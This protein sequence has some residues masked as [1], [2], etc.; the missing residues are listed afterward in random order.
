MFREITRNYPVTAAQYSKNQKGSFVPTTFRELYE[1][2]SN[3]AAGLHQLG[4]AR[5]DRLGLIADNRKEWLIADLATI[6]LGAMDVPRGRDAT[7]QE[8]IYILSFSECETIFAENLEMTLKVL[9]LKDEISSMKRIIVLDRSFSTDQLDHVPKKVEVITFDAVMELGKKKIEKRP[10][11][12]EE[13]VDK[14][15]IDDVVTIIFTSGTTG[16]PKGV[17]LTN[18]AY[19]HQ[20]SG[21]SKIVDIKPGDIWLSVLPVW[22]SFERV[23]Q[24][25]ALGTASALAYSKPIGKIMLQDFQA[26]KPQWMGSVP[27]IW[28]SIKEGIYRNVSTKSPVSRA[29]FHFFVLTGG[30]SAKMK[31][32][33]LGRMPRF[34]Y[35]SKLLDRL[36][37]LVPFILL[38]PLKLLGDRLVFSAIKK[39]LGGRFRAGVSGGGSL[40]ASVDTFFQAAGITLLNGYG[41]TETGPVVAVRNFFRPIPLTL[42]V[43]PGTDIRI[44]D[45]SGKDVLPNSK[46]RILARGPQVMKG[47]YKKPELT[48][49]ILNNEGWL[50]TGDLGVWTMDGEFD[51][52]GRFKDTIVL[53]GG[54]NLEPGPIE[55]KLR[56]SEY[57]EQAMV[58]GQDKKFL[59]VLIVPDAKAIEHYMKANHVPYISR[60]DMLE[61]PDVQELINSEIQE[62]ICQKNGFKHFER[63]YRFALIP[64]SFE[65]GNELSAKQEIK[66]HI[67]GELYKKEIKALFT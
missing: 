60:R 52:R 65:I 48:A 41:L 45:E 51:I 61:L 42:D 64:K 17:M 38:L 39:K 55:A 34:R 9:A 16:E 4:I 5:G 20:I 6:S 11:L 3:F 56:E 14:G 30:L 62:L 54:E 29:L 43:F 66:R 22:H 28:E 2:V 12:I 33:L 21:V 46:G 19:L 10:A 49:S 63:I 47:Y 50:D 31:N 26:I 59:G 13:E 35:R 67:I 1:E 7:D 53:S 27:R 24:Y 57:I 15:D 36:L 23:L 58:V 44:V 32:M 25:V 18:R 37:A 40:A 8:L